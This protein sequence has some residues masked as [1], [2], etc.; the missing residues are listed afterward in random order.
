MDRYLDLH[1]FVGGFAVGILAVYAMRPP[2]QIVHKFPSPDNVSRTL[3]HDA[4]GGHLLSVR[5]GACAVL[6]ELR[7][8]TNRG[9]LKFCRIY[10]TNP[11]SGCAPWPVVD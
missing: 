8:A 5:R 1:F 4:A 9:S 11:W 2:M 10:I 3:Y 6:R 7:T